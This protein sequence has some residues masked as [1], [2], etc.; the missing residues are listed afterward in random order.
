MHQH[1]I[2][3]YMSRR[4]LPV[5]LKEVNEEQKRVLTMDDF[6]GAFIC[7][8]L[9]LAVCLIV[10]PIEC[11]LYYYFNKNEPVKTPVEQIGKAEN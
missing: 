1:G 2:I 9:C 10:Y 6:I 3:D 11:K 8:G 4:R 7:F 5:T